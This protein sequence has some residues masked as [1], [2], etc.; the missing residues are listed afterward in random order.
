M[1]CGVSHSSH[2]VICGSK[3][4]LFIPASG[5]AER[6]PSPY[7]YCSEGNCST[8]VGSCGR[9]KFTSKSQSLLSIFYCFFDF[10]LCNWKLQQ[11]KC[12]K[13]PPFRL[14]YGTFG[15]LCHKKVDRRE[16]IL[17]ICQFD[18]N[19]K[20]AAMLHKANSGQSCN[21]LGIKVEQRWK[22]RGWICSCKQ[23]LFSHGNKL[24]IPR[25]R[26][27]LSASGSRGVGCGK[28]PFLPLAVCCLPL[29]GHEWPCLVR[30]EWCH[31]VR[32]R[33]WKKSCS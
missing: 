13:K 20:I 30:D 15:L 26:P 28:H 32:I 25:A 2:D 24:G 9:Q 27:C 7:S 22:G 23:K 11:L 29:P 1:W 12:P 33:W 31:V 3:L 8:P 6:S 16:K 4:A 18:S 17:Q 14:I 19:S 10:F 21:N 5:L